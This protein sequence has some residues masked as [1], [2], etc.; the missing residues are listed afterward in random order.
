VSD[1]LA[2]GAEVEDVGLV[3]G[4]GEEGVG[5]VWSRLCVTEEGLGRMSKGVPWRWGI[6]KVVV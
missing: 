1:I 2:V 6:A 4:G 3:K 5:F